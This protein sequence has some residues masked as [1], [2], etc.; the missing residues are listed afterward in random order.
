MASSFEQASMS[1]IF[2][3]FLSHSLEPGVIN[4]I[5]VLLNLVPSL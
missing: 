4:K 2:G 5:S 3:L 1:E